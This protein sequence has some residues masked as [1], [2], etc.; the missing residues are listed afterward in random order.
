MIQ[1][2][3]NDQSTKFIKESDEDT[4]QY[5]LQKNRK[6]KVAAVIIISFL[7]LLILGIVVSGVFFETTS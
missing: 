7:I 1:Q 6:T 5:I 3:E 2:K 4:K